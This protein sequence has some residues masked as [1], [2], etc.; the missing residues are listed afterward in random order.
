M[1]ATGVVAAVG[2]FGVGVAATAASA[3]FSA[4]VAAAAAAATAATAA[5][6]PPASTTTTATT[7]PAPM[8]RSAS[9]DAVGSVVPKVHPPANPAS[10]AEKKTKTR[11]HIALPF[12][13][14]KT[15]ATLS[16]LLVWMTSQKVVERKTDETKQSA[17]TAAATQP[18]DRNPLAIVKAVSKVLKFEQPANIKSADDLDLF[19]ELRNHVRSAFYSFCTTR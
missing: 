11:A 8:P 4:Q 2:P 10:P 13:E 18:E 14:I 9:A 16:G 12:F 17:G 6:G 15:S 3:S 1:S 5:T 19:Q 7:S